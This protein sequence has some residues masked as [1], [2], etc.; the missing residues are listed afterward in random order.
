MRCMGIRLLLAEDEKALSWALV[1]ILERSSYSVDAVFDGQT[2]LEY[3]ESE[4]Y[5]GVIL[6]VMMPRLDGFEVLK[7]LRQ[8]GNLVPVLMRQ[9]R[10]G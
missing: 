8:A 7:A 2:A 9:K 4:E 1:T 10:S 6:D 3:L 5:D